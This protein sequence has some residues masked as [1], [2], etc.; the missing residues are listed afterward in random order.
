MA[1]RGANFFNQCRYLPKTYFC[2]NLVLVLC[3]DLQNIL[4]AA[5]HRQF[6]NKRRSTLRRVGH[7]KSAAVLLYNILGDGQAQAVV[8]FI[9]AG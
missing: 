7:G 8:S 5:I 1:S 9:G 3:T 6:Q 2:P 4:L